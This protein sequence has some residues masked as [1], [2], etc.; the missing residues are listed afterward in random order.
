MPSAHRRKIQPTNFT[1]KSKCICSQNGIECDSLFASIICELNKRKHAT[2][3]HSTREEEKKYRNVCPFEKHDSEHW[4]QKLSNKISSKNKK[5]N[6][7]VDEAIRISHSF[8]RCSS[9]YA[10]FLFQ[11]NSQSI[12]MS[13]NSIELT[14]RD[15]LSTFHITLNANCTT[16]ADDAA[17]AVAR[18]MLFLSLL[19]FQFFFISVLFRI[20]FISIFMLLFMFLS[21]ART[22]TRN[23][24]RIFFLFNCSYS[25]PIS[26]FHL[27]ISMIRNNA[28]VDAK[29]CA[30][31]YC[32]SVFLLL[33]VV[34][35]S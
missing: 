28:K 2:T 24:Y 30:A 21:R 18:I 23:A 8:E 17:S 4:Q 29:W 27:M 11:F 12:Q 26:I 31:V 22:H 5:K 7:I 35:T 34:H 16:T 3:C 13:V 14:K 10:L 6:I 15:C 32:N 20:V 19:L 25:S 9:F 33:S 1:Q